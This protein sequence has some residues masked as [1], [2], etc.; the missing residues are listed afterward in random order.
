MDRS[1]FKI[2]GALLAEDEELRARMVDLLPE[3]Q[4]I[5]SRLHEEEVVGMLAVAAAR[6]EREG[7]ALF[8]PI[9]R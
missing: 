4:A 1:K 6:L 5:Y 9:P 3:A 8:T 7:I 2:A